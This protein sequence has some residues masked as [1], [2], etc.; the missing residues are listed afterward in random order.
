ML[1]SDMMTLCS[2]FFFFFFFFFFLHTAL[3]LSVL[4]SLIYKREPRR[5][6]HG[7]VYTSGPG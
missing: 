3:E 7:R 5:L 1:F 2:F 6:F 4:V